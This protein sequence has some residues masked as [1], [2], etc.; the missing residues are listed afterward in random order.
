[1][2]QPI[3]LTGLLSIALL[4]SHCDRVEPVTFPNRAGVVDSSIKPAL[5]EVDVDC[6]PL[7]EAATFPLFTQSGIVQVLERPDHK[8]LA[9]SDYGRTYLLNGTRWERDY[10]NGPWVDWSGA[11]QV[12]FVGCFPRYSGDIWYPPDTDD[13]VQLGVEEYWRGDLYDPDIDRDQETSWIPPEDPP[14]VASNDYL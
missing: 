1:M 6:E 8:L 14:P 13:T 3:R 7:D 2:S 10:E 11:P 4:L 5:F 12:Y 9:R